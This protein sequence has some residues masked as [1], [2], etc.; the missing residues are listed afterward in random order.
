M[1]ILGNHPV[2]T[3]CGN[4]WTWNMAALSAAMEGTLS[5]YSRLSLLTDRLIHQVTKSLRCSLVEY[6]HLI[7]YSS[8][9][10]KA[11]SSFLGFILVTQ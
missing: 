8:A 5:S 1:E 7:L 2:S 6:F 10:S 4:F 9:V 3:V 11:L